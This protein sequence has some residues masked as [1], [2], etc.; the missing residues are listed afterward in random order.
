M[1]FS[2]GWS[3]SPERYGGGGGAGGSEPLVKRIYESLSSQRGSAY[4][5]NPNSFVGVETM[6]YAR[7]IA[8][9]AW[10]A[11]ARLANSFIPSRMTAATGMLQRWEKIFGVPPLPGDT[12]LVRRARVAAAWAKFGQSNAIQP[13]VDAL[14]AAIAPI[15]VGVVHQNSANEVSFVNG[16]SNVV[17]TGTAPPT[18]TFSGTP[19]DNF[20]IQLNVTTGGGLGA[21]VSKWSYNGGLTFPATGVAIPAAVLPSLTG[22]V[23]LA[24]GTVNTGITAHFTVGTYAT[25][26]VYALTVLPSRLWTSTLAHVEVNVSYAGAGY[27]NVDGSPNAAF[28]NLA[29]NI[30]PILDEMLPSWATYSW[31]VNNSHGTIG[32]I[33]DDAHNLDIEAFG[34]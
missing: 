10:G 13:V 30:A 1:P 4:T 28:Y 33:L 23:P 3:P 12:E 26:N 15:Y 7:S 17:A 18:V 19:T 31:Y 32:F 25:D 5:A 14:Q 8:F 24:I 11:N 21:G 29:S 9:D 16:I 34:S 2:G 6:A 27:H 22:D 20:Q